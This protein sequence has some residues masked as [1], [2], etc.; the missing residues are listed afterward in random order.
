MVAGNNLKGIYMISE[1]ELNKLSEKIDTDEYI[2]IDSLSFPRNNDKA[3]GSAISTFFTIGFIGFIIFLLLL[4]FGGDSDSDFSITMT[5]FLGTPV[6]ALV[7][8]IVN[9]YN[10]YAPEDF[11]K[12]A[13]RI[14]LKIDEHNENIFHKLLTSELC[15]NGI[16]EL[17]KEIEIYKTDC[18]KETIGVNDNEK[19]LAYYNFTL[20]S[21][22]GKKSATVQ[23]IFYKDLIRYELIDNST[24]TQTSTSITS[25]N[26]GKALGGAILSDL[27]VNNAT[28]GAI[29]GGSG[30]RITET[31]YKTTVKNSFQI[32]IY[33]NS[34]DDS[35]ITINTTDR[36]RLK[37]IVSILEYALRNQNK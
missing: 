24:T 4:I 30:A 29:I 6:V 37:G 33:L 1:L 10:D 32:V 16:Y 20:N 9:F 12:K 15:N 26:S 31:T 5:V 23:K 34:L 35:T 2:P 25:S 14:K 28:V 13:R 7:M 36:D 11:I 17:T 3:W 21:S 19:Y 8:A 27:L 18:R 22:T